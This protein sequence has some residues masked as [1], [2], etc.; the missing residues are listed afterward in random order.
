MDDKT[1]IVQLT[2]LAGAG[3]VL[4][5]AYYLG[6]RHATAP[7]ATSS[8][9]AAE[10]CECGLTVAQ[11][12]C[13]PASSSSASLYNSQLLG[14]VKKYEKHFIICSGT[15][16]D[17]WGAKIDKDEGSFAQLAKQAISAR[18]AE[19]TF[20]FKL[21]NSDERSKGSEGTDLIVFPER[22]RYLG[23]T[24]ETMPFIVED[25]L[26]NGH[27]SERV[28]HE[29]FESEL[30]LV[31]CHNNRDTRCGAEGP[32]IVSA[33]DRLLAA[34]GLGED[35]VMVRSSSHLGGHK[36]AGVVVVYPRGD[37]FGF[38]TEQQV[39][40]LLDNYIEHGSMVPEHWRGRMGIDKQEAKDLADSVTLAVETS[41]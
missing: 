24:A 37:W 1:K 38:I 31:C 17:E 25:H 9:A 8:S 27:V 12:G 10:T 26:V 14:T 18:K 11:G 7:A 35:K 39:E 36:Y 5:G 22:I 41:S 4:L 16:P 28:K 15:E 30:V 3:A 32:I 23:V 19:L 6:T 20:K 29:P 40:K 2:A 33:F 34:R 13:A 21:T